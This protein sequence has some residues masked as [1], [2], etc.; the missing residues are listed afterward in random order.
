MS[1]PKLGV[2]LQAA[3]ALKIAINGFGR[4]GRAA[5]K[6][7]LERTDVE[8]VA[9]NDLADAKTLAYLLRY[10]T[11]YGPYAKEV[12]VEAGQLVI[13]EA[14]IRMLSEK[15]PERLPWKELEIDVVLECTGRFIDSESAGAHLAAGAKR[16]VISAPS[17]GDN[18]APTFVLGANQYDGKAEVINN[19]SCTTNSIAPVIA[20]LHSVFGVEKALM[21]TVH[22]YTAEQN[23]VD[24][25]PPG[26]K[27]N[28][29]RRAR[30][31]AE[32]II[33]TTTGA[34]IA[35]AEVITDLKNRFDGI[36][37]RVP[38][39]VGSISDITAV[40]KK[41][42]TAEEV[43]KAFEAAVQNPPYKGILAVTREP[44]VSSDVVG[45]SESAI[46][47]LE[48]TKVVGGNLVK[49]FAW[50]DNELGYS[51]RFVEQALAVGT[52]R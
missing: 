16:V 34:A 51:H 42:A 9:V 19:A 27:A 8:V 50:Y 48:L 32:N 44:I 37:L 25:P 39:A 11:V 41:D 46:V 45:R 18:P 17:K 22:G 13:G 20:V 5:C 30:A 35:T 31:A 12:R 43:N 15:E 21:T 28:D 4:I 10:D 38:V 52:S 6:V 49:V 40:L 1:T 7:A 33:P 3:M 29:L 24:G 2:M 47:D 14:R 26:G 36:A 23:L